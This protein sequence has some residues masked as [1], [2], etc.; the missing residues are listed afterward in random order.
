MPIRERKRNACTFDRF[1]TFGDSVSDVGFRSDRISNGPLAIDLVASK[2]GAAP[3]TPGATIVDGKPI[4]TG[5]NTFAFAGAPA[6]A[7]DGVEIDLKAQVG[8]YLQAIGLLD[9]SRPILKASTPQT[10]HTIGIGGRDLG[11]A[12][13]SFLINSLGGRGFSPPRESPD[14]IIDGAVKAIATQLE[15][16][17]KIGACN[18][19]V[20]S[21]T[22]I[23]RVPFVMEMEDFYPRS[24]VLE[25]AREIT[26]DFNEKLN[27]TVSALEKDFNR[28]CLRAGANFGLLFSD[29]S[30]LTQQLN[31]D[32]LDTR[33]PCNSRFL[34]D[35]KTCLAT[36]ARFLPLPLIPNKRGTKVLCTLPVLSTEDL[37]CDCDGSVFFDE[38]N[39]AKEFNSLLSEALFQGIEAVCRT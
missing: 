18:V 23:S 9:D 31:L 16:L 38:F 5:G 27:N 3:L 33:N 25:K 4:P 19:V 29:S 20:T 6:R 7:L 32:Q 10:L 28:K 11:E 26:A 22:D 39:P 36:P 13:I 17:A 24:G 12:A 8:L 34:T 35:E 30:I 2:Y 37:V 15:V 21:S 1:I 14:V